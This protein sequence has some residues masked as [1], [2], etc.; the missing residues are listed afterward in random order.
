VFD[1]LFAREKLGSTGLGQGIAIPHGRIKGL[2]EATGAFLRLAVPV[3]FD[4]PDGKPV[5]LLFVLLAVTGLGF[6]LF[7]PRRRVWFRFTSTAS[8]QV[9]V[10]CAGLARGD[11][12]TLD[13]AVRDFL[14]RF[15]G[16]G[17]SSPAPEQT[18]RP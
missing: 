8:G 17:S 10:A 6:A 9:N 16:P 4:S 18:H 14:D 5:S 2:K 11:D 1:S 12:P 7:V 3:P 13:A 15:P